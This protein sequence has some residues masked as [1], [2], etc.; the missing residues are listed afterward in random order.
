MNME[1][2]QVRKLDERRLIPD[3]KFT[4]GQ[5]PGIT[6]KEAKE[7]N[8]KEGETKWRFKDEN[9]EPLHW[10][11]KRLI[12][13]AVHISVKVAFSNYLYTFGGHTY[14]QKA[15][16]PIGSRLTMAVSRVLMGRWSHKLR[17]ILK[18]SN[19]PLYLLSAMWMTSI[20]LSDTC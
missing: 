18:E 14:R 9:A 1:P 10:D 19:L 3:I 12:A 8:T 6:S 5:R 20:W 16:G 11:L 2:D 13:L 17:D 7:K 15:G 4:M